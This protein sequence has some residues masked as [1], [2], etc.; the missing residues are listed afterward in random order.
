MR[1]AAL[2]LCALLTA[3]VTAP[4]PRVASDHAAVEAALLRD[5]TELAS[6]AYQGRRPGTEGEAKTLGYLAREWQAAGLVSGTND[7]ANAWYAPVEFAL[8]IPVESEAQ[9]W[10]GKEKLELA[11]GAVAFFTSGRR[12][13]VDRAPLVYV[14]RLGEEL[15]DS[16]LVGRV[17]VMEWDHGAHLE[18]REA[19]LASGAAAVLAVVGDQ[20]EMAE[21][22]ERRRTGV[23]R[24]ASDEGGDLLDGFVTR[25]AARFLFGPARLAA[26]EDEAA[27]PGFRPRT[28]G[29]SVTVD[30]VSTPGTVRTH[31]LI[32]RLPGRDPGAGAVLVLAHWDHFGICAGEPADT[33]C[34]GA[35]DN[36][37][38][39]AALTELARRLGA[40]PQLDRD[41]Y[42]LATTGEE[43]GLLG[44]Q[45][46]AQDPPV[47]LD[48][49]V[50]AFNLDTMAVAPRGGPVAIVG[51]GL[52]P[53]DAPIEAAIRAQGRAIGDPAYAERYLKRQDGWAL[54]QHDVPAVM[55][56]ST[57]AD[58]AALRRYT[59]TRYHKPGD[60]VA[61]IELG[62]AADDV[63]LHL[64]LVR[65]FASRQAWPGKRR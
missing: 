28:L 25:E 20:R 39:L 45:A 13:L 54:L 36:A 31:N 48:S 52:T 47:P 35:V 41:V 23:Y 40:G 11:R 30:T 29:I 49:I 42:F 37:S 57:F 27:Q 33:I 18:Q 56:S 2:G 61:G 12:A 51:A 50:A 21:L 17:A 53:L 32:G 44:A 55:V 59:A 1:A 43:W 6:D 10:R 4:P 14:G 64:A 3:C 8:S 65:Q 62:G 26:L 24:I 19:L 22:V 34:N 60:E 15:A 5:I 63:L 9:F 38:G 58:P 46:F 16:E 7:P